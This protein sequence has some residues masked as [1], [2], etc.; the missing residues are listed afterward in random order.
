[1][2]TFVLLTIS[3]YYLFLRSIPMLPKIYLPTHYS[4]TKFALLAESLFADNLLS[5]KLL[6]DTIYGMG[7]GPGPGT[8]YRDWDQDYSVETRDVETRGDQ[9]DRCEANL[10]MI[11]E[12]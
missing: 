8:K 3:R 9:I 1:M 5:D 7:P 4:P 12:I 11:V 2:F 10:L 6:A